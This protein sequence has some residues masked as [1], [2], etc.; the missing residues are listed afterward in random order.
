MEKGKSI[1][2]TSTNSLEKVSNQISIVKKILSKR[3]VRIP[4]TRNTP[5]VI[6][7]N[8]GIIKMRGRSIPEDALNF[9]KPIDEWVQEYIYNPADI[10]CVDFI[11]EIINGD[12]SKFL[13]HIIQKISYVA[14]KHKKFIINW[15]YKDGDEEILEI[16]ESLSSGVDV[17]FNFIMISGEK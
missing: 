13:V 4:A 3:Q 15:Y 7:D 12:S 8:D 9:F 5:E 2:R 10:T 17:P 16:G 1:A 14:L 6:L 11:L